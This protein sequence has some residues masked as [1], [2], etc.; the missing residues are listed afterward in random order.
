MKVVRLSALRTGRLYPQ[1]N[2]PGTHFCQRLSQLQGH[3]AVGKITSMKN[4]NDIIGNRIRDLPA[5]KA[6]PQPNASPRAPLKLGTLVF[7]IRRPYTFHSLQLHNA[8]AWWNALFAASH[9]L[10]Q[11][12]YKHRPN[13]NHHLE[14]T[15]HVYAFKRHLIPCTNTNIRK[16]EQLFLF[17]KQLFRAQTLSPLSAAASRLPPRCSTAPITFGSNQE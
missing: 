8:H 7:F 5:C 16:S 9:S 6:V 4:S 12:S 14:S 11:A 2:I 1:G 15:E 17:Q 3:S 10:S 13:N